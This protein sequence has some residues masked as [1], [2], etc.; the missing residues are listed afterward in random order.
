MSECDLDT[1][2]MRRPRPTRAL[3]PLK[4]N[5]LVYCHVVLQRSMPNEEG[6]FEFTHSLRLQEASIFGR[7]PQGL[8][9]L[10]M[11]V[12]PAYY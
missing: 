8:V 2:T 6:L 5:K 1:S 7:T 11:F 12:C 10:Q 9:V 4:K 3:E